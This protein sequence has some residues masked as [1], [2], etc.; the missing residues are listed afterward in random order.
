MSPEI[1]TLVSALILTPLLFVLGRVLVRIR[2]VNESLEA[3]E[4]DPSQASFT[5]RWLLGWQIGLQRKMMRWSTKA[6]GDRFIS[7]YYRLAGWFFLVM[8][9]LIWIFVL[10]QFLNIL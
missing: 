8:L 1:S 3:F 10:L 4:K 5:D 2:S 6:F 9:A 7:F